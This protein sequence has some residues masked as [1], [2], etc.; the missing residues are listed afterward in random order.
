MWGSRLPERSVGGGEL[1]LRP[2]QELLAGP[3]TRY[4][5]YLD[6]SWSTPKASAWAYVSRTYASQSYYKF[7]GKSDAGMG[8]CAG[9]SRCAPQDVKRIFYRLPTSTF[10]GKTILSAE[11]VAKETWSY[12]CDGRAVQLWLTKSFG[13]SSTWSTTSDN[14]LDWQDTRDVAKGWSS[15]CPDGNVEFNALDAVKKAAAGKWSATT[16]GL[17][18]ANEDDAYAW[19][20]FADD[21]YLRVNYNTPPPQP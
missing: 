16:F 9:D 19:K 21:A 5:V 14:W 3:Q 13:S 4:P 15:S 20:R 17:R 6:P 8:Y 18:A 10:A 7:D 1:A 11:F 12:S 2:D